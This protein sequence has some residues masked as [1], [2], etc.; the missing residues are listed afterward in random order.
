MESHPT[1]APG[2]TAAPGIATDPVIAPAA[3]PVGLSTAAVVT[4]ALFTVYLFTVAVAL[5]IQL[6]LLRSVPK[7]LLLFYV[8]QLLLLRSMY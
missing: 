6:L 1:T 2:V 4:A 7:L 5:C 8:W 3:V